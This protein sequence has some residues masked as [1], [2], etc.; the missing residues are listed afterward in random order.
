MTRRC[1]APE[2][3]GND[4]T[5]SGA[6]GTMP[7]SCPGDGGGGGTSGRAVKGVETRGD[8]DVN[9]RCAAG[10][11]PLAALLDTGAAAAAGA[12]VLDAGA[13]MTGIG[14]TGVTDSIVGTVDAPDGADTS[15]GSLRAVGAENGVG[16]TGDDG[17][18]SAENTESSETGG[19]TAD[20]EAGVTIDII[21]RSATAATT[22]SGAGGAAGTM[23]PRAPLTFANDGEESGVTEAVGGGNGVADVTDDDCAAPT[24][25]GVETEGVGRETAGKRPSV[26]SSTPA[27]PRR[28]PG[29]LEGT[30]AGTTGERSGVGIRG[31]IDGV[32]SGV[33]APSV[34]RKMAPQTLQR[35]RTPFGGTLAGSTRNTDRQS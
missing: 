5:A 2:L 13:A 9:G 14:D 30:L 3:C 20:T 15:I 10:A 18:R 31:A 23:A 34:I 7:T 8:P 11:S 1:S 19:V 32:V 29:I 12:A 26:G 28:L 33:V 27:V 16:A 4:G 21:G 17:P 22:D 35:A 25:P 6:G 24:V